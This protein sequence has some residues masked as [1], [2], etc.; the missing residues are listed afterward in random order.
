M[1]TTSLIPSPTMQQ[2][3]YLPPPDPQ[4]VERAMLKGDISQMSDQERIA[5]YVAT[6]K[7]MG[8][9]PLTRPFLAMKGEDGKEHLY[10]DKG[11]AEQLR[12]LHRVSIKV[13]GREIIDGLYVV[14]VLATTPDG[15]EEEAQGVVPLVKAKGT[16]KD[17]EYNKQQRRRFVPDVGTDGQEV[18]VP[19]AATERAN[20]IMRAESKA[21]RR[22]TLAIC[23]L[24]LPDW[25]A[26][27]TSAAHPMALDLQARPP[28]PVETTKP[29]ATHIA[30]VFG[31]TAPAATEDADSFY[32]PQ[33][34]DAILAQGGQIEPW[35]VWAERRYGKH[36]MQFTVGEWEGF[37]QSVRDQA[38]KAGTGPTHP[39]PPQGEP[40]A[41]VP[42][43]DLWQQEER[44]AHANG[45]E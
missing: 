43:E 7:S 19:L 8:L 32:M 11:C 4:A 34:A 42:H 13:I 37:L 6:C 27:P 23:G 17:Y 41:A 3:D 10:P 35:Y 44:E 9:N 5:Y 14:T 31:E 22:V 12:K 38:A 30:E 1:A 33:I 18:M 45:E 2:V 26:E 29:L 20:A 28:S 39:Q 24:G 16:W 40:S 36:R 15:R 25:E 21:K